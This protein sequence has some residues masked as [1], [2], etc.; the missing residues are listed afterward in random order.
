MGITNTP[1]YGFEYFNTPEGI[2]E[3][4]ITM[5]TDKYA[6]GF[7]I[8]LSFLVLCVVALM[9]FWLIYVDQN[10]Y[11]GLFTRNVTSFFN[12]TVHNL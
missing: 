3:Y 9:I 11:N 2:P 4:H 5:H 6:M 10:F 12:K 7:F 8:L 1:V